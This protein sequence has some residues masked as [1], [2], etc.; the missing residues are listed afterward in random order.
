MAA[1]SLEFLGRPRLKRT[2]A[3]FFAEAPPLKLERWT[4]NY[5]MNA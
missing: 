4:I 5:R 2:A 1:V 3:L